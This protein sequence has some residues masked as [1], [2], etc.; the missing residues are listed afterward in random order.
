M[1]GY[2][3]QCLPS[4]QGDVPSK[5]GRFTTVVYAGKNR[6]IWELPLSFETMK[7]LFNKQLIEMPFI[8]EDEILDKNGRDGLSKAIA[9][10][11]LT[12][13]IL[14]IA[15]RVRQ[16]LAV[17]ELELTTAALA[18]LNITMY[19]SWWSKPTDILCPTRIT[20]KALQVQI[21][22]WMH[23]V[24][25]ATPSP[26]SI[27]VSGESNPSALQPDSDQGTEPRSE[28]P[29]SYTEDANDVEMQYVIDR[30]GTKSTVNLAIHYWGEC[31]EFLGNMIRFPWRAVNELHKAIPGFRDQIRKIASAIAGIFERKT[32]SNR[33]ARIPADI[34]YL[35]RQIWHTFTHLFLALIYYPILAIIWSGEQIWLEKDCAKSLNTGSQGEGRHNPKAKNTSGS[36][37]STLSEDVEHMSTITLMFDKKA[38]PFVLDMVFFCE[39]VASAPFSCLAAFF[40]AI[41]GMIHCLAWDFQFPSYVEQ[42]LWRTS[43]SIISSLCIFI[44][45]VSLG[46]IIYQYYHR[47]PPAKNQEEAARQPDSPG[48]RT[49]SG[50]SAKSTSSDGQSKATFSVSLCAH[51]PHDSSAEGTSQVKPA[52][53][54]SQEESVEGT[55][56]KKPAGNS[57][58]KVIEVVCSV[59][60]ICFVLTRL[61]L[62]SL[63]IIGLRSLPASAFDTVQWSGFIP[64][65]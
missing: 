12:W 45:V 64:H 56:Q 4:E 61:S 32:N 39:D 52:E 28:S 14:Q 58:S 60:A 15:A 19:I 2:R 59:F 33:W 3:L 42:V 47:P 65:I 23:D 62:I 40:G 9:I 20:T 50:T 24:T 7:E 26:H 27:N 49:S 46:Y 54:T 21:R 31:V 34:G 30:I 63:S 44:M 53:G 37:K 18:S 57:S 25:L 41:F 16:N 1:G 11:Q 22:H 13:F 35:L 6:R 29:T 55:P 48:K 51:V 5:F 38:L 36:Y 10:T 8:P 17:T 43:S